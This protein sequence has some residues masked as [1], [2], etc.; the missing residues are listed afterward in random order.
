LKTI[1]VAV[2]TGSESPRDIRLCSE[3]NA[4]FFIQKPVDYGQLLELIVRMKSLDLLHK[5]EL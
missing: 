1:P 3:L 5:N 2:I 4:K